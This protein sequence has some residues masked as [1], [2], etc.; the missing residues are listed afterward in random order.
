MYHMRAHVCVCVRV[1]AR[2]CLCVLLVGESGENGQS[3]FA[4]IVFS[5]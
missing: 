3:W 1:C 5:G 4:R 2:A